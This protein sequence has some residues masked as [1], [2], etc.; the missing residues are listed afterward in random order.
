[1]GVGETLSIDG[2]QGSVGHARWLTVLRVRRSSRHFAKETPRKQRIYTRSL[3]GFVPAPPISITPTRTQAHTHLSIHAE[4]MP[5]H[6]PLHS[7]LTM[8]CTHSH[9]MLHVQ[10][11]PWYYR[12]RRSSKQAESRCRSDRSTSNDQRPI[13]H[14]VPVEA[15]EVTEDIA[16]ADL[17]PVRRGSSTS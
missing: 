9:A 16:R 3:L 8:R 2:L 15:S 14:W 5:V 4:C 7:P 17:K 10:R 11:P 6:V 12:A 1:M 13:R